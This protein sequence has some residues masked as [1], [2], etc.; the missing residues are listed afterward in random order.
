MRWRPL[1][2]CLGCILYS[3]LSRF[4]LFPCSR[5]DHSLMGGSDDTWSRWTGWNVGIGQ[6]HVFLVK[7]QVKDSGDGIWEHF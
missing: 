6:Y 7:R 2:E 3:F 5:T 4:I 1:R